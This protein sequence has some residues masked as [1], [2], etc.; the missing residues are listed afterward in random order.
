VDVHPHLILDWNINWEAFA[1]VTVVVIAGVF[2]ASVLLT[3][4]MRNHHF[5]IGVFIERGDVPSAPPEW[6]ASPD[7]LPDAWP[8]HREELQQTQEIPVPDQK[9][10]P[11]ADAGGS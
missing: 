6:Y 9:K 2:F 7:Q 11:P 4:N 10:E 3:R 8:P 1:A 5:R